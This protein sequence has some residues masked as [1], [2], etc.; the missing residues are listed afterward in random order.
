[1]EMECSRSARKLRRQLSK[2]VPRF[3][4][5]QK[6]VLEQVRKL[7]KSDMSLGGLCD[8]FAFALALDVELKQ[9]LLDEL[10][11][12]KRVA[13]LLTHLENEPSCTEGSAASDRKFPPEF[14]SN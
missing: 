9:E 11:V 3:F 2:L 14:S 4:G 1:V 10:D 12:E 8:I 13:R 5:K 6:D 7:F